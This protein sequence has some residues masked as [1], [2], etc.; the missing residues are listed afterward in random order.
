MKGGLC[1]IGVYIILTKLLGDN[2]S[3]IL[4]YTNNWDF[5]MTSLAYDIVKGWEIISIW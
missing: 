2:M 3:S 1:D 5:F 4:D